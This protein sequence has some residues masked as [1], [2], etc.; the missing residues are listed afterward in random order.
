MRASR[1]STPSSRSATEPSAIRALQLKELQAGLNDV[2]RTN[3][4]W[5]ERLNVARDS[6]HL[7]E[8]EFIFEV[9]ESRELVATNL[10]RE[11]QMD[12]VAVLVE[13]TLQ[14]FAGERLEADLRPALGVRL[15]CRV[16]PTGT[17]PR[18]ELTSRRVLR[19]F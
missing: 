6:V 7:V 19:H 3:S 18:S 13:T 15:E 16:V 8:S 4:F 2:L 11:L 12:E 1:S 10:G 17:L 9:L 14:S 5:R